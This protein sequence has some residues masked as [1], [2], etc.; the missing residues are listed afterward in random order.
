MSD[1]QNPFANNTGTNIYLP[2]DDIDMLFA[3]L[4]QMEPPP[5]LIAHI[6]AQVSQN[7]SA[8]PIL[9]RPLRQSEIDTWTAQTR[10]K[11]LC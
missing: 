3:R 8:T 2:E 10:R 1:K 6:L 9:S 5:L 7:T 4:Q 11:N